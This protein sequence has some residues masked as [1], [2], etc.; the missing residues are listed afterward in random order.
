[1]V[2]IIVEKFSEEELIKRWN[3]LTR[4][5]RY[6]EKECELCRMPEMLHTGVCTRKI[7]IGK[8]EFTELNKPRS[9]FR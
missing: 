2:E 4:K 1:M 9:V 3:Q 8:A 6:W 7:E 5:E